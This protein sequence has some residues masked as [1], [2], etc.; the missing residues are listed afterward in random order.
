MLEQE[1]NERRTVSQK[2]RDMSEKRVFEEDN[3]QY[4]PIYRQEQYRIE[5]VIDTLIQTTAAQL[6]VADLVQTQN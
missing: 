6:M 4:I 5:S 2:L 1:S 3:P